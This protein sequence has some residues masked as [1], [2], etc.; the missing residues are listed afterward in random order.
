MR[1]HQPI[2]RTSRKTVFDEVLREVGGG[3]ITPPPS[4]LGTKKKPRLNRVESDLYQF[5]LF[6]IVWLKW[7]KRENGS[8]VHV[9]GFNEK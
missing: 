3:R 1:R 9:L 7:E 8:N 2:L 5:R 6:L 4:G